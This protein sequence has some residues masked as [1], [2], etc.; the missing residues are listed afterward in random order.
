[1]K[2]YNKNFAKVKKAFS[3]LLVKFFQFKTTFQDRLSIYEDESIKKSEDQSYT[4]ALSTTDNSGIEDKK[5]NKMEKVLYKLEIMSDRLNDIAD[6]Y[7]EDIFDIEAGTDSKSVNTANS[8]NRQL[9]TFFDNVSFINDG[10]EVERKVVW[11]FVMIIL[12]IVIAFG[13]IVIYN[14]LP[15]AHHKIE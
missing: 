2:V 13:G 7:F 14:L 9:S 15:V 11:I 12:F 5:L 4:T 6:E 1:M 3:R 10:Q 8:S